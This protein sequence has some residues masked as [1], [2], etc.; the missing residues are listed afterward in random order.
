M[1][2]PSPAAAGT[3][4]P[5]RLLQVY[6]QRRPSGGMQP[7]QTAKA[8]PHAVAPLHNGTVPPTISAKPVAALPNHCAGP[9]SQLSFQQGQGGSAAEHVPKELIAPADATFGSRRKAPGRGLE[10][11]SAMPATEAALSTERS[12]TT[13]PT[14]R[15]RSQAVRQQQS[16]APSLLKEPVATRAS[17]HPSKRPRAA[18]AQGGAEAL[19]DSLFA[20]DDVTCSAGLQ[21]QAKQDAGPQRPATSILSSDLAATVLARLQRHKNKMQSRR[22]RSGGMMARMH[23]S[24]EP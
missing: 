2:S 17:S 14:S 5:A 24:V 9:T 19:F 4:A 11:W 21:E 22:R 6:S 15:K 20:G 12:T 8:A 23:K 3:L 10:S 18:P 7:S 13:S 16:T 1:H